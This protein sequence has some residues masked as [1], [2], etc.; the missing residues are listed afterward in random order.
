MNGNFKVKCIDTNG[1]DGYT[2]GKI[3]KI[4]DGKFIY[5]NFSTMITMVGIIT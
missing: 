4:R 1:Y 3:Y 2:K 5:D